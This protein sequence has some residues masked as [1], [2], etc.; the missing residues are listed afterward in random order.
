MRL[1]A[2]DKAAVLFLSSESYLL[3]DFLNK[4]KQ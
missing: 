3:K 1:R 2:R 4:L